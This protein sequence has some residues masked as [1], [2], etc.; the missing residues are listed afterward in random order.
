MLAAAAAQV[1]PISLARKLKK[2]AA[3]DLAGGFACGLRSVC[4]WWVWEGTIL[5]ATPCEM[6]C[7]LRV[8]KRNSGC[9]C[10]MLDLDIEG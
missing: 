2:L 9:R 10:S 1:D 6:G 5:I 4:V 7:P 8:E 3:G